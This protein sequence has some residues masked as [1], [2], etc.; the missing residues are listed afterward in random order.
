MSDTATLPADAASAP[1][2]T[3]LGHPLG[4]YVCFFVEMFERFS[5]YGMKALLFLYLTKYHLFSDAN[6]Y[7]LLGTY[8]GLAY[9]LPVLGGMLA[10]RFLG[11][12]KAV[13][14]G[15]ILLVLGHFGMAFEGQ[16]ART[17]GGEVVRDG[18]ALQVFYAS[19]AFI[20]MG[21]GF[22]KPNISTIVGRLYPEAD[23][24]RDSGFTLF[25]MGI[26][27][28]AFVSSLLCAYL[29]ETYGWGYGFGAAGVGMVIGLLVFWF[30]Q[31]HL[32]GKAESPR[33]EL[34]KQKLVAGLNREWLI[35]LGALAGVAVV[36]Q[37]LQTR[38]DFSA[39]GS[40][41]GLGAGHEITATEVVAI[42]LTGVLAVWLTRFLLKECT[43]SERGRMVLLL[44][45]IAVSTMFWGLYEQTYGTWLAFSDRVMNR[46]ALGQEWSAG[47]LTSIGAFFIFI[48]APLFS[49]LWPVLDR[50]RANPSAPAKFGLGLAFAGLAM[51]VLVYA[52]THPEA[53]GKVGFWWFVLAYLVL[54][55]GEM[56]LSPIGLSAV[57]TLSVPRVVSLM[58]GVW[59]LA[60]AFGE[61]LAGRFGTM[62]AM[63]PNTATADALVRYAEVFGVLGWVGLGSGALMLVVSPLLR[64]LEGGARA[65]EATVPAAEKSAPSSAAS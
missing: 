53:N 43:P 18:F 28:G 50:A 34:L 26:N 6:G 60:S 59:F 5:F 38:F 48:L 57:T 36:W 65:V 12:R 20:I 51:F 3:L 52:A 19:L 55:V 9:A 14:F 64:R 37:I 35:Y 33:P 41:L 61:M 13:L 4:L 16:A 22:L 11:M 24:R 63:D 45:I 31:K 47:Q 21:V 39:I 62:A 25:Y 27:I 58:M 15:G 46:Q 49:W 1:G 8:A 2:R 44:A 56:V 30:F 10:D 17:V 32:Q 42:T 29:G 23:P 40:I 7:L 54:E